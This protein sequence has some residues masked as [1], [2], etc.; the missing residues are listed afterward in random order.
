MQPGL[1]STGIPRPPRTIFPEW[2]R[3][4]E[5]REGGVATDLAGSPSGDGGE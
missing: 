3:E 2:V 4:Y 5:R 1:Q